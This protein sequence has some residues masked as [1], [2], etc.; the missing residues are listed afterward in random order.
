MSGEHPVSKAILKRIN[1]EFADSPGVEVRNMGF[2]PKDTAQSFGVGSLE[3]KI[4]CS[5][6]NN[7]LSHLDGEAL[8]MFNAFEAM[9]YAAAGIT[10]APERVYNVDGDL[11]ERWML[12]VVCGGLY[13]GTMRAD[14]GFEL[15]GV[16]PPLDWLQT[17]YGQQPFPD[18]FGIYCLSPQGDEVFT[19]D[20]SIVKLMPLLLDTEEQTAVHGLRLWMFGFR[21]TLLAT[22]GQPRAIEAM[23][24][25]SY[26]PNGFTID[27]SRTR[28]NFAWASGPGSGEIG[29]RFV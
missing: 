27:G 8:A 24:G 19:I 11:L 22:G 23:A 6:H 16:E 1:Q 7:S 10:P 20:R 9:H 4:L 21:F 14:G 12:K 25:Q 3:S 26:R 5:N 29:L 13:G 18:G 17:V 28:V 2:Q 15:K